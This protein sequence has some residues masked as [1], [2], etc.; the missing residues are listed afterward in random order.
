MPTNQEWADAHT[1]ALAELEKGKKV[2]AEIIDAVKAD[3][4]HFR[5]ASDAETTEAEPAPE[6]TAAPM[7]PEAAVVPPGEQG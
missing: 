2:A 4:E 1:A 6:N 5:N 7:A 3:I